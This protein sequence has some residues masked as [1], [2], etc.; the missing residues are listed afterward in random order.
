MERDC[1]SLALLCIKYSVL[2]ACIALVFSRAGVIDSTLLILEFQN[3]VECMFE[4]RI[5]F[6]LSVVG[7]AVV[8][9]ACIHM[10]TQP[11]AFILAP[12]LEE[13]Q[14]LLLSS[15]LDCTLSRVTFVRRHC[16]KNVCLFCNFVSVTFTPAAPLT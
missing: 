1:I 16:G 15:I 9:C 7:F 8:L 14:P 3:I 10:L 11:W 4:V 2:R 5:V 13:P 6:S 12:L